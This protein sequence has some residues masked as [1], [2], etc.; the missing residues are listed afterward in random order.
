LPFASFELPLPHSQ[1]KHFTKRKIVK[2]TIRSIR[3]IVK[4]HPRNGFGSQPCR[5]LHLGRI[6]LATPP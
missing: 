2:I 4:N 6:G 5:N 3:T 1:A